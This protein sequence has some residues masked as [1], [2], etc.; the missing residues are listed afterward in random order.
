MVGT[1]TGH[2]DT[3]ATAA[4]DGLPVASESASI[5]AGQKRKS[6]RVVAASNAQ[7]E[8]LQGGTVAPAEDASLLANGP[9][10]TSPGLKRKSPRVK[11]TTSDTTKKVILA[12]EANDDEGL[13]R[14]RGRPRGTS[15]VSRDG[16]L[17]TPRSRSKSL[18]AKGGTPDLAERRLVLEERKIRLAEQRFLLEE[19]K[20]D[21]TIEIGKGLIISMERMTNTISQLGNSPRSHR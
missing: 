3:S 1:Q 2:N 4:D 8:L 18:A 11:Q 6:P 7:K 14:P 5:S 20:L 13:A 15:D 19:K 16:V 12:L 17:D 9:L 10:P 21:A